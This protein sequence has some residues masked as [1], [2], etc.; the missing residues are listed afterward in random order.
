MDEFD[1]SS[2]EA[3][4]I[5]YTAAKGFWAPGW[6]FDDILNEA[7]VGMWEASLSW[8]PDGGSK[9]TTYAIMCARRKI[10]DLV[11]RANTQKHSFLRYYTELESSGAYSIPEKSYECSDSKQVLANLLKY[12]E[13]TDLEQ[14]V[15]NLKL[16]D[17]GYK[18]IAN[19][20]NISYKT[21]DNAVQ[22]ILKK[23]RNV[24]IPTS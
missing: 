16:L 15:L 3:E 10:M 23:L 24:L 2:S 19:E 4:Y 13:L 22:R 6:D 5:I 12:V 7:R 8:R 17:H 18:E 1:F 20:L 11:T 14:T 9:W 21:V